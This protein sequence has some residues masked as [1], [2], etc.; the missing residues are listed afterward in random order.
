MD[1]RELPPFARGGQADVDRAVAS[2]RAA[3]NDGRWRL[4]S[5]VR[6]KA[7]LLKW[8]RRL[9][10]AALERALIETVAM[11]KTSVGCKWAPWDVQKQKSP[12]VRG[13]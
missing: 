1:G 5:P 13:F 8:S 9:L 11:G 7:V 2:A 12:A 10:A 6:R 3:F 4:Q